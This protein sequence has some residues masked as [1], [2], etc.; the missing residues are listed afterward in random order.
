M[1]L[2][3]ADADLRF[4]AAEGSDWEVINVNSFNFDTAIFRHVCFNRDGVFNF[5][6][7]REA[8]SLRQRPFA[9]RIR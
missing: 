6:A 2:A 9:F 5:L 8:V 3:G 7:G 4:D 1:I